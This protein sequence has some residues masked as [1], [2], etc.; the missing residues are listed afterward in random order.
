MDSPLQL[1]S[2]SIQEVHEQA[3]LLWIHSKTRDKET[4]PAHGIFFALTNE[5]WPRSVSEVGNAIELCGV[6][7][8][9]FGQP[10][11]T[12]EQTKSLNARALRLFVEHSRGVGTMRFVGYLTWAN[13]LGY[14]LAAITLGL[15][16]LSYWVI[17]LAVAVWSCHGAARAAVGMRREEPRPEWELPVIANLHLG[18]LLALYVVSILRLMSRS[19]CR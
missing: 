17:G 8:Q 15:T 10:P 1:G 7:S 4:N 19:E 11:L 3:I 2:R 16:G 6:L 13:R 14:V 9:A 5:T 12:E 18:T